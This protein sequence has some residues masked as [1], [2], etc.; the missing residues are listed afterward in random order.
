MYVCMHKYM[1]IQYM[2][3]LGQS[4]LSTADHALLLIAPATT[5]LKTLE[6]SYA[7]PDFIQSL[8]LILRPTVRRPVCLGLLDFCG[9]CWCGA[10]SL[11]R[12]RV[13]NLL[14][15]LALV[16]AVTFGSESRGTRDHI[17]LHQIRDFPFRR[18]LRLAGLRWGYSTPPQHERVS[19][20]YA[21]MQKFEADRTKNISQQ[22][23]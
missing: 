2:Q 9:V 4:R 23:F 1:Y 16:S 8:S 15:L 3:G 12:G 18:L 13:C 21:L 10:L 22:T 17:L 11:T 5:A 14:L 7:W 20:R 19:V 6:R